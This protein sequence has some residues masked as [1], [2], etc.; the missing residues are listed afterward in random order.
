MRLTLRTLL[1]YLDDTL[2]PA[3]ATVIGRKV[4]ESENA[5]EL[6][7]K[8]KK[9]TRKRGL[10]TPSPKGDD[11][12]SNPNTVAEY[13]SDALSSEAVSEFE[14]DCL[15]T[16]VNLAE[17]AACHQILTLLLSEPA[18]VPPVA[19]KRMYE[20]VKGPESLPNRKPGLT[21]PV[22]GMPADVPKPDLG[23]HDASLLLGLSPTSVGLRWGI[24]FVLT[25]FAIIATW[26][27]WPRI[28]SVAPLII[29]E[30]LI[31]V[32]KVEE[33]KN[34]GEKET[35]NPVEVAKPNPPAVEPKSEN[36]TKP[37]TNPE[38]PKSTI[39]TADTT[40]KVVGKLVSKDQV[41]VSSS[42]PG[43][44]SRI[45]DAGSVFSTD[46]L[47][48][49]PG[50]KSKILLDTNV[51]MDFWANLPD[52]IPSGPFESSA[53]I[54]APTGNI[55]ADL[56]VQNGRIYLATTQPAGATIR[57]RIDQA[58][59]DVKLANDKSE[60][61]IESSHRLMPGLLTRP[62]NLNTSDWTIG[63]IRGTGSVEFKSSGM[64]IEIKAGEAIG[65]DQKVI[66]DGA[67]K[68]ARQSV[69]PDAAAAAAAQKALVAFSA[70]LTPM[71]R[72][73]LKLSEAVNSDSTPTARMAVFGQAAA[74]DVVE[75]AKS[76]LD[77]NRPQVRDAAVV[78]LRNALAVN[79]SLAEPI[80]NSMI[81]KAGFSPEQVEHLIALL[82]G[83]DPAE[84]KL[85]EPLRRL[86][87]GLSST[88]LPERE[89]SH[90]LLVLEIDPE[91]V[92]SLS[93]ARF[94]PSGPV[95]T[96]EACQ[97]LWR[98]RIEELVK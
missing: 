9:L 61:C 94:D 59:F 40:R 69:Y 3:E 10:A 5:R 98:K 33:K 97:K 75:V 83:T 54:L 37:A 53:T 60:I 13:L 25:C 34:T 7:E 88:S 84:R 76:L 39:L 85:I 29:D 19:R 68:L 8:I 18:R 43:T 57:V 63:V 96:R 6:I 52:Q 81:D 79:P 31:P 46:R 89:L 16:E 56:A 73:L 12:S 48:C 4:A 20:L 64:P 66:A 24:A 11:S 87:D 62:V 70:T 32:P 27:A 86:V 82:R 2:P 23:E 36:E 15:E 30:T 21:V 78:A 77:V 80:K 26:L 90:R 47:V 51:T 1:A 41:L 28:A 91:S 71:D 35:V 55:A 44:W 45:A 17:V 49:L 92:R 42:M 72:V 74:G 65:A 14:S 50:Y 95:E 22:G 38:Q 67:K 93:L 58:I